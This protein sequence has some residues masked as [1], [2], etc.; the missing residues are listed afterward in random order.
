[1]S[2]V[3]FDVEEIS[4]CP[5]CADLLWYNGAQGWYVCAGCAYRVMHIS[6]GLQGIK[7]TL[8]K[9]LYDRVMDLSMDTVED[10]LEERGDDFET[11]LEIL[12]EGW[13]AL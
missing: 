11:R 1:M 13:M 5:K 8:P 3:F 9:S 4:I 12:I 10:I 7:I 6:D 2:S